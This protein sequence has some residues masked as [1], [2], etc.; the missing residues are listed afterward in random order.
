MTDEQKRALAEY[1]A[2]IDAYKNTPAA[3]QQ[4]QGRLSPTTM[5][6][7]AMEG[8]A[9][10]PR[11]RENQLAALKALEQQSREGLTAMDRADMARTRNQVDSAD[12]GRRGA[13]QQN[14]QARGMSGS[15]MELVSQMQG[16]QDANEI[17]AMR[18]LETEGLMQSRKAQATRDLGQMSGQMQGQD[19]NQQAQRAQAADAIRRFNAE[20]SNGANQFN[21]QNAQ[22]VNAANTGIQNQRTG[23]LMQ[24]GTQGAEMGYNAATEDEN[25]RLLA[26][27]ER[28]KKE[29]ARRAGIGQA[30]G[31][32]AGGALGTFA[33]PGVGTAAGAGMGSQLGGLISNW[34]K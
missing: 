20:M 10:D 17:A 34:G 22:G 11:F 23:G 27:A 19:F 16:A 15:G 5:D 3:M 8:V 26:E 14:M 6:P 1:Q 33:A 12:R 28:K 32:V 18:A 13:I 2:A 4:V 9:T 29:A 31:M 24:A 25:R 30:V 21:I 7:S